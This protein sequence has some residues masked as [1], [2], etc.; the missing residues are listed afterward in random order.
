VKASFVEN[1]MVRRSKKTQ[2]S[3]ARMDGYVVIAFAEDIDQAM[4]FKTLL[5]SN[6][7]P[8]MIK[9]QEEQSE[10]SEEIAVMVPEE[11][12][13]E[14]HVII[15]S[16]QAYDDFCDFALGDDSEADFEEDL[17]EDEY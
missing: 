2:K 11:Y 16:Q 7:V 5:D 10:T 8:A 3:Q 13:D 6:D 4:E 9:E 15:E 12:I 17:Y 14:A 1:K